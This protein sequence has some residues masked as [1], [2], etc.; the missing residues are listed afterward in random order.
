MGIWIID[1]VKPFETTDE[2]AFRVLK[3][4]TGFDDIYLEQVKVFSTIDRHPLSR[5]ITVA[6]YSLIQIDEPHLEHLEIDQS[7]AWINVDEVKSLA[8]DHFE[9]MHASLTIMRKKLREHPIGFNLLPKKFTLVQIQCLYE[10]ILGIK[11]D[12]RNFRRKIAALG[13]LQDWGITDQVVSHRP[14]RQYSFDIEQYE[15]KKKSGFNFDL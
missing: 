13:I 15:K 6:Y 4:K 9:I 14:A 7:L 2:A 1:I 10:A 12:K 8:F 11:L 3:S 5:V